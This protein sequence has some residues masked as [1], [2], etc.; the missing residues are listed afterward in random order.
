MRKPRGYTIRVDS[1]PA[2]ISGAVDPFG[3]EWRFKA[4]MGMV[5]G[6]GDSY[7]EAITNL[8]KELKAL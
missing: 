2:A 3:R 8:L 6:Y 1:F 4:R 7:L 5:Y